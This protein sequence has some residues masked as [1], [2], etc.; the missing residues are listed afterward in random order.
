MSD[1]SMDQYGPFAYL[2]LVI[3]CTLLFL[4][5]RCGSCLGIEY[6][7]IDPNDPATL[8]YK[9]ERKKA[10]ESRRCVSAANPYKCYKLLD[11]RYPELPPS[12]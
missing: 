5:G 12:I 8:K 10:Y 11:S 4:V 6:W 3:F 9:M 1:Q 7:K 2:F